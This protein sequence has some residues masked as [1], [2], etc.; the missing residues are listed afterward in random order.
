MQQLDMFFKFEIREVQMASNHEVLVTHQF[1][2]F[3]WLGADIQLT[4]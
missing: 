4:K 3:F 1:F 2:H